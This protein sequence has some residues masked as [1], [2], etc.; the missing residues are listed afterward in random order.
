VGTVLERWIGALD[1]MVMVDEASVS[2][3]REAVRER[4]A[5]AGLPGPAIESLAAAASELAHNQLRHA[6]RGRVAVHRVE[7]GGVPGVEVMAADAGPGIA[8]PAAALR[9]TPRASGSLGVGL[10]AAHRLSDE[11]DLEVRAGEGTCVRVRRFAI[12]VAKSE[13]AILSRTCAGEGVCGDDGL[14]LRIGD[15]L[16]LA[17]ADGLG[18]GPAA[19]LAAEAA[20]DVI[21]G[22]PE[23]SLVELLTACGPPLRATR[24]AVAAIARLDP[25]DE[26]LRMAGAGN[27]TALVYTLAGAQRAMG[28][29]HILGA[30]HQRPP[31]FDEQRFALDAHGTVILFSDGITSRADL[32]DEPEVLRQPPIAVAQRLLE[33]F[34]RVDDDA[35]VLVAR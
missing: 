32:A 2:L 28:N 11:M 4:G 3:V 14:A 20:I 35:L 34:G 13:V 29:A 7:R 30:P 5:E 24:G 23:R 16:L 10:S 15:R 9:G 19:R 18:H 27:V 21:A 1:A 17:V 31:R 8:D 22:S 6:R 25:A 12:P 26:S 33:R